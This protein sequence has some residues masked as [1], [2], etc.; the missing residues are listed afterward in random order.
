MIISPLSP[1]GSMDT[2]DDKPTMQDSSSASCT[3]SV[4]LVCLQC[5]D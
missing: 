2:I 5:H 1:R 3:M 4:V